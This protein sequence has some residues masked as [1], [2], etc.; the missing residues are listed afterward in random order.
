MGSMRI[1]C[2]AS[3]RQMETYPS[4]TT[5]A[6]HVLFEFHHAFVEVVV[7]VRAHVDK[8]T[9]TENVAQVLLALPVVC[10]VAGQIEGLPVLD[11]LVV[12]L[13]GDFI[14]RLRDGQY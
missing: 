5:F 13:S 6:V 12:D 2:A 10:D 3:K 4:W 9:M 8:D 11:G 14:P 1:R 7:V